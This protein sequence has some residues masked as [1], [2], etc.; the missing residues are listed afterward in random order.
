[1]CCTKL[2]EAARHWALSSSLVQH[3]F[4]ERCSSSFLRILVF[5]MLVFFPL[6]YSLSLLWE[7]TFGNLTQRQGGVCLRQG[8][9]YIT[10]HLCWTA[11]LT[12]TVILNK[13]S[14][15]RRCACTRLGIRKHVHK[16]MRTRTQTHAHRNTNMSTNMQVELRNE[17]D[18][19]NKK[20]KYR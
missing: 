4:A 8:P 16:Q 20:W 17:A 14:I 19:R 1:M 9:V 3:L 2:L 15:P 11:R 6:D 18:L 10:P 7:V 12:L 13:N 5:K